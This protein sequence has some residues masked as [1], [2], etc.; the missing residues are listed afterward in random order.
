MKELS[1]TIT[2]GVGSE[3]HNHDLA[4]RKGL[5]HVHE[6]PEGVIE[7]VGYRSYKDQINDAMKPY[8]AAY[9]EN[10]RRRKAEAQ[11]RYE[12]GIIKTKPRDRDFQEM[13]TDYYSQELKRLKKHEEEQRKIETPPEPKK[14]DGDEVAE[15]KKK[16]RKQ[17]Q[18]E[19]RN[20]STRKMPPAPLFRSLIIGIGDKDDRLQGKITETQA[21]K[22]LSEVAE[23]FPEEFPD[24]L[25][26]GATLHLDEEGFYHAHLDY[27]PLYEKPQPGRGL[28]VGTGQEAALEHMGFK[29]EQSIVNGRDKAPL[30]FNAFRNRLYRMMEDA[31]GKQGLRLQYGVSEVK[32]PTKN[33]GKN[34]RLEVWQATQDAARSM[35]HNKNVALDVLSQDTVSPEGFKEA[36]AAVEDLK[37]TMAEVETTPH[38]VMRKEYRVSFKLFDQMKSV[39]QNLQQTM[40]HLVHQLNTAKEQVAQ[41][42]PFK[43]AA[44][45][46]EKAAATWRDRYFEAAT[47]RQAWQGECERQRQFMSEQRRRDG[48]SVLDAYEAAQE[49]PESRPEPQTRDWGTR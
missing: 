24:F 29:P 43:A 16:T 3:I 1:V 45:R 5:C 10:M 25:L 47:E 14:E 4:Y 38:A 46:A 49:A 33:S 40:V 44:E 15:P 31:M 48:R 19:K 13:D 32:D 6:R 42:L 20:S 9:N 35:Q 12:A 18:A 7:V 27:K 8:I 37:A 17:E 22:I 39:L 36:M 11:A 41:L 26:L 34:Q 28:G 2:V 30:L 21:K 23:R